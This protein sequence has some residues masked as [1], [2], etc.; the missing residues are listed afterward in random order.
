MSNKPN[1]NFREKPEIIERLDK[2]ADRRGCERSD[3]IRE[4]IREKLAKVEAAK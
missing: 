4:A 1:V 2:E 3:V